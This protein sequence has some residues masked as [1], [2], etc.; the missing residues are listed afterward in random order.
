MMLINMYESKNKT[1][2]VTKEDEKKEEK[3]DIFV[4][5]EDWSFYKVHCNNLGY[6]WIVC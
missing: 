2:C 1:G 4:I 5:S 6:F 3:I